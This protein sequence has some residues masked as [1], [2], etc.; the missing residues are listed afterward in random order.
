MDINFGFV[1]FHRRR[2]DESTKAFIQAS[3]EAT[4]SVAEDDAGRLF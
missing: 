2:P 4:E 3:A 1:G